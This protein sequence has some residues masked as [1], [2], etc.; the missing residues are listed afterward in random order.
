MTRDYVR[1]ARPVKR[2]PANSGARVSRNSTTSAAPFPLVRALLALAL[3]IGFGI[4]LYHI[5][6]SSGKTETATPE[7]AKAPAP[8]PIEQQRPAK[9]QFDYMQILQ[10][11]EVPVTLPDG[12]TIADPSQDPQLLAH[13][14]KMQETLR[15]QQE[16]AKLLAE[17]QNGQPAP[18]QT[19]MAAKPTPLINT[20]VSK[21]TKSSEST[22]HEAENQTQATNP[23]KPRSFAEVIANESTKTTNKPAKPLTKSATQERDEALAMFGKPQPYSSDHSNKENHASKTATVTASATT[24][25][26]HYWMQCGAFHTADQA[27]SLRSRLAVQGQNAQVRDGGAWHRVVLGPYNSRAVAEQALSRLKSAGTI[28]NC[29]VY[30]Q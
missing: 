6:G 18:D 7:Q 8:I 27:N 15:A 14:Q 3:V 30:A 22:A 28:Q 19:S 4:F 21:N 20:Q 26:K 29:T 16:R 24:D 9:E 2:K 1:S 5:S 23:R 10:N 25:N 13:Q 12:E 11:K 17:Q